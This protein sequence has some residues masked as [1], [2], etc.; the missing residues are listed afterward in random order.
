M[1]DGKIKTSIAIPALSGGG[2]EKVILLLVKELIRRDEISRVYVGSRC[3]ASDA[4]DCEVIVLGGRHA[5]EGLFYFLRSV[6]TDPAKSF[7]LT[8]GYINFTPFLRIL[9]PKSKVIVRIGNTP[10]PEISGLTKIKRF[11]YLFVTCIA[12][13]MASRVIA[14]C[15]FMANDIEK[16]LGLPRSRITRIY[17]P[18][19][20]SLE[21]W[22]ESGSTPISEPYLFMAATFRPQKDLETLVAGFACCDNKLGRRLVIAGVRPDDAAFN[23][24]LVR[25]N[26][27]RGQVICLGFRKDTYDLIR[28]SDLCVLTSKYE[29]F[30]NFLLEAAA[31]GKHIVATNCPGGNAELFHHYENS[32]TFAVGDHKRFAELIEQPRQDF[33]RSKAISALDQFS[34]STFIDKFRAIIS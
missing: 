30:S 16:L 2:A 29:G 12:T 13:H 10:T 3:E 21:N 23:Q 18:I 25:Y 33:S 26:L 9:K 17:N 5:S 6:A 1:S 14:Q 19:E 7:I 22:P 27:N 24:L 34:F 32:S 8:L 28:G 4:L 15:D 20:P 31:L 11:K